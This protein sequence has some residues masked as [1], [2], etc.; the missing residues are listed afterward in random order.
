MNKAKEKELLQEK[1]LLRIK[2]ASWIVICFGIILHLRQFLF[3]RSLWYDEAALAINIVNRSF[4]GLL[5]PLEPFQ[6]APTGFLMIERLMVQLF[7]NSE[8]VLRL[9]PLIGGIASIF[10]FYKITKSYLEP[11]IALIALILFSIS[12]RLIYF[13]SEVKRYG[14]ETCLQ[15]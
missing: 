11:K 5:K 15:N 3:N 7:G 4:S 2:N 6:V 8:Y 13:S 10:L 1:S 12:D 9:F 14:V